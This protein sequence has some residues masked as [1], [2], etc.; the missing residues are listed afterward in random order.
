MDNLPAGPDPSSRDRDAWKF[1]LVAT[2]LLPLC[3]V[4]Y[5][6][7]VLVRAVEV[8]Q[9]VPRGACGRDWGPQYSAAHGLT[10]AQLLLVTAAWI[11]PHRMRWATWRFVAAALS[12]LCGLACSAVIQHFD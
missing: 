7:F 5:W 3:Q 6:Y 9:C 10:G 4:L 11:L 12:V 2:V 8:D 1:P